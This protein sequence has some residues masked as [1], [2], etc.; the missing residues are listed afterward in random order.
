M[1]QPGDGN[2]AAGKEVMVRHSVSPPAE[3]EKGLGSLCRLAVCKSA[4]ARSG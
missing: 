4:E 1:Q 3:L 2:V